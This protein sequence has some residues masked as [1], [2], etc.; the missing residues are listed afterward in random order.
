MKKKVSL[1]KK[2][3]KLVDSILGAYNDQ[4]NLERL[5]ALQSALMTCFSESEEL[6][7]HIHFLKTRLK[8]TSSLRKKLERKILNAKE[9]GE[10]YKITPKNL[11]AKIN[12]LIGIR[13]LHLY[14]DQ[15][16]T[17]NPIM[18]KLFDIHGHRL[19]EGPFARTWDDEYKDFFQKMGIK[20]ES[21]SS[22]YTSVHYIIGVGPTS[23]ELTAE[24]QVRTLMEEVWGE[25]DHQINYPVKTKIL[26]CEEQIK[27]LA[28]VTSSATRLVD[29][30]FR[31]KKDTEV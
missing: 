10:L 26:S 12:D 4:Y 25:V 18:K 20:T 2:E 6:K 27:V 8:D 15:I 23:N 7:P 5:K 31:C 13:I 24:I 29:S 3:N 19:S 17:I 28:R 22:L 11:F 14:T 1:N 16:K 30:I 21:S 9:K